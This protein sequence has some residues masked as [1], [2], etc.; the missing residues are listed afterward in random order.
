MG[1]GDVGQF[2]LGCIGLHCDGLKLPKTAAFLFL[3]LISTSTKE[4]LDES[5]RGE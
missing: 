4:P 5:E 2:L 3:A 1:L